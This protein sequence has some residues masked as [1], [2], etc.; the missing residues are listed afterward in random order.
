MALIVQKYGGTSVG[1]PERI[2]NVAQ[3]VVAA[4]EAGQEV[5]VVV[6]AMGQT[7]D[8]LVD[9]AAQISPAPYARELD[10]LLSAGERISMALLSMAIIELGREAVSFTGSQAGIVTDTTHGKARIVEVRARRVIEALDAGKIVIVAGFQG[11]STAFDVTTLGRGGSDTTAVALAAALRADA[12]EI[13]TDVKGVYTADPRIVPE[14]RKLHAVS[15]EEMLELSASGAKV[16]M[17]RSVEYARNY[18]VRVH[19]RSSFEEEKGTWITKEDERMEQAIISGIAHDTSE[20]KVT[21][22]GV[23]DQPGVAARV[24]RPLADEG[25]NVDMIVQNASSDGRT[26]IFFT[27]P[28]EDLRRATPILEGVASEVG[29]RG[30]TTDPDIAKV[31][32]VGAGMKTHPGVA[33][34]MFDALADA[35]INIEIISTSSI[36]VSCVI[37]AGDVER[38]VRV[39]HDKFQLSEEVVRRAVHPATVTGEFEALKDAP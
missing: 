23:P 30:V 9:M 27:L 6:S 29:A 34:S 15:Y 33:A 8:E 12:C 36:R 14:A 28:K 25:V 22:L 21:I 38:A 10:M 4:A 35:G 31:S 39:I 37:R 5:C 16:L 7:T 1:D 26:D 3:R 11:V 19:V 32:L 17:L 24:F 20:A 13:Y 18:G 2:K